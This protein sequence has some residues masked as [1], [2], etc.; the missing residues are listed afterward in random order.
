[1]AASPRRH[2]ANSRPNGSR[3]RDLSR[4]SRPKKRRNTGSTSPDADTSYSGSAR[5]AHNPRVARGAHSSMESSG[6]V[7]ST[8]PYSR[9]TSSAIYSASAKRRKRR[10]IL[11][12]T[13]I[14]LVA[15]LLIG[16]VGVVAY[17]GTIQAN[18][19]RGINNEVLEALD[20][21]QP[22]DPFYMLLMGVDSS[23][24]REDSEEYAGDNFRS[25]S[26]MLLRVDPPQKK[27]ACVSLIRD[28]QVDLGQ[29]G[30][31]KLNAAHNFGGIPLTIKT[32]SQL[33]GVPISHY[34]EINFDGFK[35][36]VDALGGVT[37]NVPIEIDD[38][39]AEGHLYPGEQLLNGADALVLCRSRHAYD[40]IG[41]GDRYRAANQRMVIGAIGEKILSSDPVTMANTIQT[42][43]RYITTDFSV[44]DI[45]T[46]ASSLR[47]IDMDNSFYTSVMPTTP[48]YVNETWWE[49][50]DVPEWQAMIRRINQGLP[51][52]SEDE[53][54]P[55]TGIVISNSGGGAGMAASEEDTA[56]VQRG[57]T[58]VTVKNGN[59][60]TGVGAQAVEIIT[61][62]GFKAEAS[63]ANASD[64]PNTVVVYE[65]PSQR[66]TAEE[67]AK[68]LGVGYAEQNNNQYLYEGDFLVVIGAD[69]PS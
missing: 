9:S 30:I 8:N 60:R 25:D 6:S 21:V 4:Y 69:W 23:Q 22:G 55:I 28:T 15:V 31:Q 54:D 36:V 41:D 65:S 47:G 45:V 5:G 27:V 38:P 11:I 56:R 52:T 51:P 53:I 63:N 58:M 62:L 10:K 39:M 17:A 19:Q 67:I 13:A 61:N 40:D 44:V 46:L 33:A 26:M 20:N 18:M 37:V 49:I 64:Y 35:E 42:L 32:V 59:G 1:M 12:G 2:A 57:S 50:L 14:G 7:S 43:S 48:E 16:V 66:E 24:V 29:Y 34:A 68:A 3:Q